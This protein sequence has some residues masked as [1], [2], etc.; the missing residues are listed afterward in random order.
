MGLRNARIGQKLLILISLS[1][2]IFFLIGGTGFYFMQQMNKNSEQM[3][4]DALLPIKW[5]SEIRTNNR[6]VDGYTLEILLTKDMKEKQALAELIGER[7]DQNKELEVILEEAIIT[8]AETAKMAQFRQ[9]YALYTAELQKVAELS[10]AGKDDAAYTRYQ[11]E[12]KGSLESSNALLGE[13]GVYLAD[14][15]LSKSTGLVDWSGSRRLRWDLAEK[16]GRGVN[17][18]LGET[19]DVAKEA[20]GKD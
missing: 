17:S 6:A 15:L 20:V 2:V 9:D 11:Q 18:P 19:L 13:I 7:I 4:Q 12:L 16:M 5:Q 8:D 14:T 10:F 3:Y 1:V